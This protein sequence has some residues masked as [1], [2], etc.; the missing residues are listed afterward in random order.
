MTPAAA[1]VVN[2]A[3][4]SLPSVDGAAVTSV[5]HAAGLPSEWL[6]RTYLAHARIAAGLDA[7]ARLV[8]EVPRGGAPL[9]THM[10]W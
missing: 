3:H 7:L 6:A 5:L 9:A 10:G 4:P 8:G 1:V 2:R